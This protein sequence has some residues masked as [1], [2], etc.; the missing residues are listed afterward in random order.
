MKQHITIEQL[1]QLSP[2][3]QR[4]LVAWFDSQT[5]GYQDD[6]L[7]HVYIPEE[8]TGEYQGEFFGHWDQEYEFEYPHPYIGKLKNHRG[9]M[10]PLLT[11]GQMLEMIVESD[12]VITVTVNKN[13]CDELWNRV[14]RILDK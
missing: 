4:R 10:L 14:Q 8:Q 5:D 1:N 12:L 6:T 9:V 11:I 3:A 7:V 13:V 2:A